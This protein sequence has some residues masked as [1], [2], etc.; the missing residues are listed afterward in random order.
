[1]TLGY[2]ATSLQEG[3]HS[4]M[5]KR[6]KNQKISLHEVVTFF[7]EVMSKRK[8]NMECKTDRSTL[9]KLYEDAENRGLKPFSEM[10]HVYLTEQAQ[11]ITLELL[12]AGFNYTVEKLANEQEIINCYQN[13]KHRN[14]SAERFKLIIDN[15]I[16]NKYEVSFYKI[17]TRAKNGPIDIVAV[18]S[19]GSFACTDP[20][21]ANHGIPSSQI[22]SVFIA[23]YIS[24]NVFYHFHPLYLQQFTKGISHNHAKELS[25]H[26][27]QNKSIVDMEVSEEASWSFAV[28]ITELEWKAVGLGGQQ[29]ESVI[30]PP[31]HVIR[32]QSDTVGEMCK[33]ELQKLLPIIVYEEKYRT[34]IFKVIEDIKRIQ[35]NE[36]QQ[37]AHARQKALGYN[38]PEVHNVSNSS[39]SASTFTPLPIPLVVAN[40]IF[41]RSVKR[42]TSGPTKKRIKKKKE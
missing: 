36:A 32:D 12:N 31:L 24:L 39:S 21:F 15:N 23:G 20:Y 2:Q 41:D 8:F 7:R 25:V 4:S 3:I 26:I 5:K 11:Q 42:K 17:M 22:M 10:V 18:F 30:N 13:T 6:L 37:E 28:K 40:D 38:I 14:T 1:M 19:N 33:K 9:K 34:M 35:A 16:S 27:P 29:Y